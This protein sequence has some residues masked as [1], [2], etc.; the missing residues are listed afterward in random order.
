[1]AAAG[2]PM[3]PI[4]SGSVP[5][6]KKINCGPLHYFPPL[7]WLGSSVFLSSKYPDHIPEDVQL[8]GLENIKQM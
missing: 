8:Q 3:G 5:L 4:G 6:K 7:P 1:M 2:R